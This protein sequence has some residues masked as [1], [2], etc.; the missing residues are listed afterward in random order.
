M[1]VMKTIIESF[2]RCLGS[3]HHQD[4]ATEDPTSRPAGTR[5]RPRSRPSSS[6]ASTLP[7]GTSGPN[8]ETDQDTGP[9]GEEENRNS[10]NRACCE[11]PLGYQGAVL[12][13]EREN[14]TILASTRKKTS[15]ARQYYKSPS[16]T[17]HR[18]SFEKARHKSMKRK[19]DIFRKSPEK[20]YSFSDLLG[21]D[22]AFPQMLCFANPVFE[23]KDD[24][25]ELTNFHNDDLTVDEET[26]AS[27]VYFDA[28]HEHLTERCQPIPLLPEFSVPHSDS[29]DDIIRIFNDGTHKTIQTICYGQPSGPPDASTSMM[30]DISS[31]SESSQ[32]I[33]LSEQQFLEEHVNCS[34]VSGSCMPQMSMCKSRNELDT[35]QEM[36][37]ANE[38][39][40]ALKLMSKSSNSTTVLTPVNSIISTGGLSPK[41]KKNGERFIGGRESNKELEKRLRIFTGT[42][43]GT[44]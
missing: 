41:Q 44:D 15:V 33:S 3:Q 11:L 5:S 30:D 25:A 12:Y 29:N 34:P 19:L 26:I 28:K 40:P 31:G 1:V 10:L 14:T 16:T 37:K 39:P 24:D 38:R 32:D 7:L 2:S 13:S 43:R 23:S 21:P 27:T 20:H 8:N 36:M 22:S 42:I 35:V 9:H 6:P 17:P 4:E 18:S